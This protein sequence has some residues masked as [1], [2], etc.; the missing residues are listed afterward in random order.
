GPEHPP[1]QGCSVSAPAIDEKI[2]AT[3]GT[4][5]LR[6][7][8]C[9]A[10]CSE[11][12]IRITDRNDLAERA[13]L[14]IHML[15]ILCDWP[16]ALRAEQPLVFGHMAG[17]LGA[18]GRGDE[19]AGRN[20]GQ[21]GLRFQSVRC[22]FRVT[23]DKKLFGISIVDVPALDKALLAG[24]QDKLRRQVFLALFARFR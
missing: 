23:A 5:Q 24:L 13:D 16:T 9:I 2:A 18:G 8:A 10:C 1:S 19:K 20:R 3:P 21:I 7:E 11:L 12:W 6:Q 17:R 15:E 4:T 14:H 22:T